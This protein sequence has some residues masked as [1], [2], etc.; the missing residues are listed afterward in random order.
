MKSINLRFAAVYTAFHVLQPQLT[1]TT[2]G[3]DF[4]HESAIDLTSQT[5][6]TVVDG[7]G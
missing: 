6:T 5:T 3:T 2:N 7:C 4:C 1:T